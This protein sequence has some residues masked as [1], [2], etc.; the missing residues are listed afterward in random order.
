MTYDTKARRET[1]LALKLK[2]GIRRAGPITVAEFMRVCLHDPEYG[3]YVKQPAIG[4]AGD[5]ITAPEISQ[6]FGELIGLWCAV[7]WQQMGAPARVNLVELGPGRGTLMRDALRAAHKVPGFAA[8]LDVHLVEQSE[9]LRRAQERTLAG[10]GVPFSFHASAG[11]LLSGEEYLGRDP[12]ILVANE[13]L[14]TFGVQQFLFDGLCWRARKIG[15]DAEGNLEFIVCAADD[16]R[17]RSLPLGVMPHEGAIFEEAVDGTLFAAVEFG[18]CSRMR[19]F[20]ALLIDYGHQSTSFGDT[21][22][23]V[24]GHRPVSPFH[25]PGET[26]LTVQV[27]FAQFAHACRNA[28]DGPLAV[29]GPL[30]QG[31][32]LGRLGIVERASRLMSANPAMAAGIEMSVARLI[33][34]QGMGSRFQ[35]IGVRSPVLPKLPGFD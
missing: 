21:L 3:Y 4:R 35:A 18:R 7:V 29:D 15:L 17:P 19:P 11:G 27:D 8:A 10:C 12:V 14:D 5:F 9:P 22:Q 31:E 6:I 23:A 26:D 34:P 32:F 30:T 28:K 24:A 2:D 1:P 33:A 13:F 16:H 25:A 20:A